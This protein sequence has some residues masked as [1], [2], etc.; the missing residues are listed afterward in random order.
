MPVIALFT[1]AYL[2][3]MRYVLVELEGYLY[4]LNTVGADILMTSHRDGINSSGIG[5]VLAE[6]CSLSSI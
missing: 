1:M 5:H 2:R 6:Y 3:L 4:V